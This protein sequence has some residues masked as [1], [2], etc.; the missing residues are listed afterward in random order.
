MQNTTATANKKTNPAAA[1]AGTGNTE[2]KN[3]EKK[4]PAEPVTTGT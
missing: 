3:N 2:T 4:T 1:A